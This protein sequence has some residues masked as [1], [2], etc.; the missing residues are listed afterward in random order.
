MQEI[1]VDVGL[2]TRL[3]DAHGPQ[4][5]PADQ[6]R[7]LDRRR[8]GIEF[9]AELRGVGLRLQTRRLQDQVQRRAGRRF[10]A[11]GG[12]CGFRPADPRRI[13]SAVGR[14]PQTQQPQNGAGRRLLR[15]QFTELHIHHYSAAPVPDPPRTRNGADGQ[16]TDQSPPLDE[17]AEFFT[18]G[19]AGG[20]VGGE[21]RP[22]PGRG[23][24]FGQV[25]AQAGIDEPVAPRLPQQGRT[26]PVQPP[27]ESVVETDSIGSGWIRFA[28]H[29]AGQAGDQFTRSH[30]LRND[31][32]VFDH[33]FRSHSR[34][35]D[36]GRRCNSSC[37]HTSTTAAPSRGPG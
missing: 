3:V 37:S 21:S 28:G 13:G 15:Q 16:Q 33:G 1:G 10:D 11:Q 35:P 30:G 17:R 9:G 26:G 22:R 20:K 14:R 29:A 8:R 7:R 19:A 5:L 12:Q 23:G 31:V 24:C 32:L 18:H 2:E 25:A 6:G 4:Q 34:F 27:V 36:E